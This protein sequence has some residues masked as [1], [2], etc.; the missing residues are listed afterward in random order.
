[1]GGAS[2]AVER[3][4]SGRRRRRRRRRRVGLVT[5]RV[6]CRRRRCLCDVLFLLP[7]L[8]VG[9]RVVFRVGFLFL[10][11]SAAGDIARR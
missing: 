6:C 3:E 4:G 2:E 1:M 10:L 7:R 5:P 8:F 9:F 11:A